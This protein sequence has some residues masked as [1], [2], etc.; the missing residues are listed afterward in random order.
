[1]GMIIDRHAAPG[2][3]TSAAHA[4][5]QDLNSSGNAGVRHR[6]GRQ[7]VDGVYGPYAHGSGEYVPTP[8]ST[9]YRC[10]PDSALTHGNGIQLVASA[11]IKM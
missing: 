5:G 6:S 7:P 10:G 9:G 11:T 1:M 3:E 4:A 8:V 2:V